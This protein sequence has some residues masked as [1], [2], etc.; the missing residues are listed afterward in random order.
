LINPPAGRGRGGFY[1]QE[2]MDKLL[3]IAALR[4]EGYALKAITARLQHW[5]NDSSTHEMLDA[6]Q[7]VEFCRE[8]K[9]VVQ[10]Q[11]QI[12]FTIAPGMDLI[13]DQTLEQHAKAKIQ[14][15]LAL[16]QDIMEDE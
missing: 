7:N 4:E 1:A 15:I 16:A 13:V 5:N 12:R 8:N 9:P 3:F 11:M 2:E 10:P 6:S 14:Q